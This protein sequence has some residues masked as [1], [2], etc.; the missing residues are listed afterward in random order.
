M[1]LVFITLLLFTSVCFGDG[2][3]E[4]QV[5]EGSAQVNGRWSN[6]HV[7]GFAQMTDSGYRQ[8]YVGPRFEISDSLS[9]G[10][11]VGTERTE[12]KSW[13]VRMGAFASVKLDH[14]SLIAIYEDGAVTGPFIKVI[15]GNQ[16]TPWLKLGIHYQS[17]LGLSPRADITLTKNVT[18]WGTF[19][20]GNTTL[21]G[22][23]YS[24]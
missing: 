14:W 8:I 12:R 13:G 22:F 4:L 15:G 3:V 24:F 1:P 6:S 23:K 17:A 21:I 16:V 19:L 20:N 18:L 2:S 9:F 5:R 7:F 10:I 11:G